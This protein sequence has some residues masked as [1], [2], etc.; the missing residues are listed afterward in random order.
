MSASV[1][2]VRKQAQCDK[3]NG[4]IPVGSVVRVWPGFKEGPGVRAKT[5]GP[6]VLASGKGDPWVPVRFLEGRRPGGTDHIFLPHV[7]REIENEC[8]NE[9]VP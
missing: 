3:F 2:T 9:E 1:S 5:L 7:G 4:Q 6:A 8:D